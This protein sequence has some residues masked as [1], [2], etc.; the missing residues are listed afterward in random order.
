MVES[1]VPCRPLVHR[2]FGPY[3]QLVED[4][5]HCPITPSLHCNRVSIN[6]DCKYRYDDDDDDDKDDDDD[7]DKDDER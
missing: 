1:T 4:R 5:Q 6:V 2:D 7:D 3:L